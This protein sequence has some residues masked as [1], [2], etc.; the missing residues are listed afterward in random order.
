MGVMALG[1]YGINVSSMITDQ[2]RS[3]R[4]R[5][6]LQS[7]RMVVIT[8]DRTQCRTM[9]FNNQTAELGRET[10]VDCDGRIGSGSGGTYSTFRDGFSSR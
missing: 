1:V 4:T 5:A 10:L 9:S 7:G 3:D 8:E 6:Q 2:N